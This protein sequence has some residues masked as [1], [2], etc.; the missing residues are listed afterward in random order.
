M[1]TGKHP[2]SLFTRSAILGWETKSEQDRNLRQPAPLDMQSHVSNHST[3]LCCMCACDTGIPVNTPVQK[4][5]GYVDGAGQLCLQC[6]Q[7][8]ES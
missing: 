5:A 1:I 6:R 7:N 4:R 3:E 8:L 2:F